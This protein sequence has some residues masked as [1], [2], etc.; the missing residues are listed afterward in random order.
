LTGYGRPDLATPV[1]LDA[2]GRP[3]PYGEQ[4][5]DREGRVPPQDAYSVDR[6]PE[7]FLPLHAVA[8]ALV[9]HLCAAFEVS[10][11]AA[12]PEPGV[13]R[14]LRLQPAA[15]DA[16]PLTV[17]WRPYPS[18]ELRV[19]AFTREPLPGCGCEACDETWSS[20][21]DRLEELVLACVE[22]RIGEA[23]VRRDRAWWTETR[24]LDVRGGLISSSSTRLEGRGPRQGWSRAW[25][26]WPGRAVSPPARPADP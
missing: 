11:Q 18:V 21:A 23:V 14:A 3:I 10:A 4:W 12:E 22:G 24:I 16:A 13:D 2:A 1:F 17:L 20:A 26:P 5:V 7:R 9:A 15:A 19:G 25:A 8:D 6:H